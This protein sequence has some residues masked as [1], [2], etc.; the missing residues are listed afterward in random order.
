VSDYGNPYWRAMGIWKHPNGH[1]EE[2][3]GGVNAA[4]F[5]G[6]WTPKPNRCGNVQISRRGEK[7]TGGY[8][9]DCEIY[10]TPHHPW[11]GEK[12]EGAWKVGFRFTQRGHPDG[13]RV[14]RTQTGGAGAV[15]LRSEDVD[16]GVATHNARAFHI[17]EIPDAADLRITLDLSF[18]SI[19]RLKGG[20]RAMVHLEGEV[21]SSTDERCPKEAEVTLVLRDGAGEIPDKIVFDPAAG[22]RRATESW[23]SLNKQRV[24]VYIDVP[25]ETQGR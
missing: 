7:L 13:H 24:N 20:P 17:D 11:R 8:W 9:K 10:C 6:C 22:C 23:T 25:R 1:T 21:K 2:F 3:G 12:K 14:I 15:S 4:S 19:T 16:Y 18:G 5:S